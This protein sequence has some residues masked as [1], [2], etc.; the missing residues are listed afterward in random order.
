MIAIY[1]G[2][3][4][5]HFEMLGY[6]IDYLLS[7]K[8]KFNIY[9]HINI[10]SFHWKKFYDNLFIPLAWNTPNLFNADNYEYVFLLTDDDNTFKDN[11]KIKIICIEHID[12]IRR[13]NVKFRIGTRFFINRP[14]CLWAIPCYNILNKQDKLDILNKENKINIVC[15]GKNQPPK[16]DYLKNLFIN[17]NEI[18]FYLITREQQYNY[19]FY[20]NIFI[21]NNC[22]TNIML[23]I[24][25]KS[26]YI[27]C[28]DLNNSDHYI[29]QS[30]SASIPLSFNFGC[31]LIIPKLWQNNYN[32]KSI[33]SYNKNKLILNK[34]IN[35]DLIYEE[36][37]EIINHRNKI[38]NQIIFN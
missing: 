20:N 37:Q 12:Y 24:L 32:F 38:F 14:E 35:L 25:T 13:I 33:I 28:L 9:S 10:F 6:I 18:N 26:H 15:L 23:D 1:H 30:I 3:H 19:E 11:N 2:F 21:Y 31:Q 17:F 7:T 27:L 34:N 16:I 4:H 22:L 36:Q 5:I 8:L 29:K